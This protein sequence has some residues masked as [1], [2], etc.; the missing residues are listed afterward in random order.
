MRGL[1]QQPED[2]FPKLF[3]HLIYGFMVEMQPFLYKA[4]ESIGLFG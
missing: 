3:L 4:K 2:F 1:K